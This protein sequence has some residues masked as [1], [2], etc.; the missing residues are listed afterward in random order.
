M[1]TLADRTIA[2]LRTNHDVLRVRVTGL[3]DEQLALPSGAADWEVAQVL[4]H[5]GS[6]A[7]I[8]LAG[9]RAAQAGAAAPEQDFNQRVWDRW[10]ALSPREQAEGFLAHDAE[11]VAAL[12]ALDAGQ[13]EDLTVALGFLPDPL[14]LA[15]IAGM[16]LNEA[17]LHSWDVRVAFDPSAT[18]A[19]DAA[20]VLV[21]QLS[22]GL[23]FLLG[24]FAKPDT[25]GGRQAALAVDGTDLGLLV[26]DPV[27]LG[28]T[29]PAPT[30]TLT[31]PV[32]AL[33]RLIGGRLTPERTPA[34]V[35]VTGDVS[36][37]DLRRVFPGF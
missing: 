22:G 9:L 36:L 8:A 23:A 5:L 15:A 4:S 20:E 21:E 26:E 33:V 13:R 19:A 7:E 12:E 29:P 16:R 6:G 25:L 17:A 14:P 31:A 32:E 37:D 2:A 35:A 10:N 24:F 1:S 27:R 30:G 28:A 11:L 34:S 3:S 18:V